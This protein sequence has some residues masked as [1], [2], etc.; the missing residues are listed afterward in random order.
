[1]Y[2]RPGVGELRQLTLLEEESRKLNQLVADLSLDKPI[3]QD[4]PATKP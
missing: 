1:M 4:L 2:G 3:P